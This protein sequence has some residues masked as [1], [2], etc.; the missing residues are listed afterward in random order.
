MKQDSNDF[1][2]IKQSLIPNEEWRDLPGYIGRYQVSNLGRVKALARMKRIASMGLQPCPERF[3]TPTL[4]NKGRYKVS[5]YLNYRKK[6]HFVS[7]LVLLA[8]IGD[9]PELEADHINHDKKDNRLCNLEWV[10]PEENLR[11]RNEE[12]YKC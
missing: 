4:N 1:A 2:R 8:F 3:L 7:R 11:R 10:T 6:S 5:L 12:Y 9:K